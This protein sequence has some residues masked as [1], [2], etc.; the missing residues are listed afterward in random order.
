[1]EVRDTKGDLLGFIE[2][3]KFEAGKGY[4][5]LLSHHPAPLRPGASVWERLHVNA[6]E[7]ECRMVTDGAASWPALLSRG[8]SLEL[9]RKIPGFRA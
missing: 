9:L 7:L 4:R 2:G 8:Y 3:Y 5:F 6:V 1:M